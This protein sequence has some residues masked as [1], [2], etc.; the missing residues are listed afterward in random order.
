MAER[1]RL[2]DMPLELIQITTETSKEKS[3]GCGDT[4]NLK[5]FARV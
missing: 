2:F 5:H 3:K 1:G 4:L